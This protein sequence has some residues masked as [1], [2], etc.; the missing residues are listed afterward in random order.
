MSK[1][2]KPLIGKRPHNQGL[3]KPTR[4]EVLQRLLRKHKKELI[5][6]GIIP[7]P[8]LR[9]PRYKFC[10]TYGDLNGEVYADDRSTARAMIKHELG[11]RKKIRLPQEVD[12]VRE[13]NT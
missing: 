13:L 6:R 5:R 4:Q 10:W 12:I 2:T 8:A 11:I 3:R 1:F 9:P 7:D